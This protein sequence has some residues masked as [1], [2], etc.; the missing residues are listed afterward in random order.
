MKN[1]TDNFKN[2]IRTYGRQFDF[3]F[4]VNNI[5]IDTDFINSIN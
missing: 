1:V 4:K 3:N 5:E 2:D